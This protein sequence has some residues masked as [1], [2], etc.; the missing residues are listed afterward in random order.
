MGLEHAQQLVDDLMQNL[1]GNYDEAR[2]REA[3]Q[4][5]LLV[6]LMEEVRSLRDALK[7]G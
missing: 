5:Q 3:T 4:A 6:D 7:K 1:I 2:R